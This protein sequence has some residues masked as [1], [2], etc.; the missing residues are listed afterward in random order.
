[1]KC[2]NQLPLWLY[3]VK[4]DFVSAHY[5][6]NWQLCGRDA[7]QMWQWTHC[8][9]YYNMTAMILAGNEINFAIAAGYICLVAS[10]IVWNEGEHVSPCFSFRSLA[11]FLVDS[12]YYCIIDVKSNIT[13]VNWICRFIVNM[14]YCGRSP[15]RNSASWAQ[16]PF[17][18]GIV[19]RQFPLLQAPC[20]VTMGV[21]REAA[22][23]S[24]TIFVF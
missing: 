20:D 4:F 21:A 14:F 7:K 16:H 10:N 3:L 23:A 13:I 9:Q 19:R 1:M 5:W 6:I 8:N 15:S 17:T 18:T 22:L 12:T 2:Q 11:Q 24:S